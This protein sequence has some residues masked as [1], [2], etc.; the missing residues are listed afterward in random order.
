[1]ALLNVKPVNTQ[2]TPAQELPQHSALTVLTA[3]HADKGSLRGNPISH[4]GFYFEQSAPRHLRGSQEGFY[5]M[6]ISGAIHTD[7]ASASRLGVH[8]EAPLRSLAL[9]A[10][11]AGLTN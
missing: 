9:C 1:M 5:T 8:P 6:K 2:T 4:G 11:D 3:A 7:T 10:A